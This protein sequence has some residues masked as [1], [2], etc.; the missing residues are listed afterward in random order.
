V[1]GVLLLAPFLAD[2]AGAALGS[3]SAV[4]SGLVAPAPG[5][6][7]TT[8]ADG[9]LRGQDF[10]ATVTGVA[11]PDRVTLDGQNV[12]A[13]A[14]RRFVAFNLELTEDAQAVAP[15]GT[16][17]AV[18]A[19]VVYGSDSSP[20]SLSSLNDQLA[21]Q[22]L[23]STWVSGST[24]FVLSVPDTTHKVDLVLR[25][26]SFSQS[27]DLWSLQRDGP[28]PTV[29]YRSAN[30]P[31]LTSSSAAS[32]TLSL[33]NPSDGFS[34]IA[35]VAPANATL[36]YFAAPDAGVPT[37]SFDQAILS[38]ILTAQYPVNLNDATATGH[39]LGAQSPLPASFLS[40][41]PN[42][43]A[44]LTATM[45][46][47]DSATGPAE[48]D[49]LFDALYSFVVPAS[50]TSGTLTIGAGSF[51]GTEFTLYTA[52]D[53]STP[54][55][56][57]APATM[58]VA[59]PAAPISAQQKRAPWIGR[60]L[61]PTAAPS[62]SSEAGTAVTT[63]PGFPIW[64][65]VLLL[66]LAAGAVVVVQRWYARRGVATAS[67]AATPAPVVVPTAASAVTVDEPVAPPRTETERPPAGHSPPMPTADPMLKLFGP[68]AFDGYRQVSVR[69]VV[70]ELLCWLVLHN[71]HS[72]NADEIQL[73]L[74]PT[75]GSRPEPTRKTFHSYLSA[76]RQCIGA[77][78]LPDATNAGGYRV[79][80]IE[81]DWFVFQRLSG[82]A[83]KATGARA[84]ELRTQALT[85]VRGAPFQVR[86]QY[87]WV[88]SE[89][90]DTQMSGAVI[91][92][93]LRLFN[94]LMVLGRYQAAED[95]AKA[96]L[97]GATEDLRLKQARD[98]AVEARNEGLAHP[99]R[100]LGDEL[101]ADPDPNPDDGD[102][103]DVPES[104]ADPGDP[105][106]T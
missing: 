47:S 88:F 54:L 95:A 9:R 80:G 41:T 12:L 24:S 30:R 102:G 3:G 22:A 60:A 64:L 67:V 36:S 90:L 87:E 14:G 76:L 71:Q 46:Q 85:L 17:P 78:H 20:L 70:E 34:G 69:R 11:W 6:T 105:E 100:N 61:P 39:Y 72:H 73:A 66:V 68:I 65:A 7:F 2:P 28:A 32:T 99:G 59:F 81:C 93:A 10:A 5:T 49:G 31:T 77:E 62:R 57:T 106:P 82:E 48:D 1:A 8:P 53:G 21:V 86:G 23:Q 26:G 40:F 13:T 35:Q 89:G 16:D 19:A 74:R 103:P 50:L 83:D 104:S 4:A 38:V 51:S 55:T 63:P 97:R 25:Q 43:A 42:G 45:S 92:C 27:F 84:I 79:I 52:E 75:E 18:T 94:D 15:D 101:P 58:A 91:T 56:I 44:P 33:N 29:L 96:G 37:I 98:R